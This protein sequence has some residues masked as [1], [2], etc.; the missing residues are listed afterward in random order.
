[1]VSCRVYS[2]CTSICS[3][4]CQGTSAYSVKCCTFHDFTDQCLHGV[5]ISMVALGTK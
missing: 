1:M 2:T 3:V 5:L 4:K